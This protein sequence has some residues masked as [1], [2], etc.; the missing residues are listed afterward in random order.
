MTHLPSYEGR[1]E[2]SWLPVHE[3]CSGSARAMAPD[4]AR[5]LF[6]IDPAAPRHRIEQWQR[7][8]SSLFA[9]LSPEA[10]EPEA[11]GGSIE[12]IH[13]GNVSLSHIAASAQRVRREGTRSRGR[14]IDRFFLNVQIEGSGSVLGE[15]GET[16]LNAGDCVLVDPNDA[17][18]L[19][20]RAPF[21]QLCIQ[22]PEW[23]LREK[24]RLRPESLVGVPIDLRQGSGAI[25]LSAM[26]A[27]IEPAP[28]EADVPAELVELFGEV[29]ARTLR[30]AARHEDAASPSAAE[31]EFFA[32]LRQ[33][34]GENY[35][36]ETTA[37]ADA[38]RALGCS[39]R[40]VHKVCANRG[41]TFGTLLLEAR[42]AAAAHALATARQG[43]RISSIGYDSGFADI[44]HFNRLFR[45]QFGM[46]PGQ[47]R[48]ARH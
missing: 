26:A 23:W 48:A 2:F 47:Y 18:V 20:F 5:T 45:R 19:D 38:A 32:C 16:R 30:I 44:S 36:D 24:L 31:R 12:T 29:M 10:A 37:P 6:A 46:T 22:I 9:E 28:G 40:Y 42:L 17:Y 43:S 13:R 41:T 14:T 3:G 8:I 25:L 11:F 34:I 7:A 1:S 33:F 4:S 21:R 27:V 15:R 35:R 39:L